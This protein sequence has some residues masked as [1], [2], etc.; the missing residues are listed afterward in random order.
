ML[1]D[2]HAHLYEDPGYGDALA[3]TGR[4][5]GLDWLCIGGGAE[6]YGLASND[7]VLEQASRYPELF[8]PFAA[9][10]LG[11]DSAADVEEMAR[12]GF[13]GFRVCAPPQPYD[14]E[15]FSPVYEAAEALQTPILFHTGF[16][17]P[18]PLDKALGVRCER[19]RPVYLDSVAR[20]FPRL[21]VVGTSLGGPWCEEACEAMRLHAGVFFDL[22]S[23]TLRKRDCEFLRRLLRS[24]KTSVLGT[25]SDERAC[26]RIIFG[27][28]VRHEELPSMERDYQRF[29]RALA[30]SEAMINRVMGETAQELLSLPG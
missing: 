11:Q 23:D 12:S 15:R 25:H 10:K 26:N 2:F 14:D 3:E 9:L 27:S 8:L 20:S 30:F 1:V 21:K 5:L 17:P 16:L 18:S 29:F 7:E 4:N 24:G 19:M 6:R 28:A 22:S 13:R